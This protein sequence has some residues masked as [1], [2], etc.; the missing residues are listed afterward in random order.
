[1]L[2]YQGKH[3]K[4]ILFESEREKHG[5]EEKVFENSEKFHL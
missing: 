1:M 3:K 2:V 4:N 5:R